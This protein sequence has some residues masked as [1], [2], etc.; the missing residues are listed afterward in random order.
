MVQ[1][2]GK[3]SRRVGDRCHG[4]LISVGAEYIQGDLSLCEKG[5]PVV[6]RKRG[7]GC[8]QETKEM[9]P[10]RFIYRQMHKLK[11]FSYTIVC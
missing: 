10:K 6:D 11:K 7:V 2:G 3:G 4:G 1:L 9:P 8:S 5:G